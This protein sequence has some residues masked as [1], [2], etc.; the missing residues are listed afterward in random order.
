MENNKVVIGWIDSGV[1]TSGFAAYISQILL[2]RSDIIDGVIAASGPYLSANRNTMARKFLE[3]TDAD[4]LLSLDSDLLVDIQSFDNLVN[5]LDVT[6][7]QV[8]SGKYYIPM[9]NKI[10]LAAMVFD[11]TR[12]FEGG[13][14]WVDTE[15]P[16]FNKP[17][18]DNLASVGGGYMFIHRKVLET[19][20]KDAAGPMPWFQD[21]WQDFP[22]SSWITDDI[23]FFKQVK[24][25]N[26][27]VALCT[28]A[29]STHLKT[30]KIDDDVY[31]AF[32]NINK[33]QTGQHLKTGKSKSWWV[34]GKKYKK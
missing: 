27:N 16:E 2:H 18:I 8:L 28:S 12:D 10:E 13:T 14:T 3:E 11:K 32:L 24:K 7:Y 4:W 19:I 22:Y 23:H 33:Y 34:K 26:F 15:S 21:Y 20:L 30:S 29:T 1:V 17:I 9:E 25:H 6:K 31:L 5:A